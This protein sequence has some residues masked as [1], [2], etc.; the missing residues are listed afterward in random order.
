MSDAKLGIVFHDVPRLTGAEAQ[1]YNTLSVGQTEYWRT[2]TTNAVSP[3]FAII[4]S[5]T[6]QNEMQEIVATNTK[7]KITIGGVFN[8]TV[9]DVKVK[10]D[11]ATGVTCDDYKDMTVKDPKGSY[12]P[13]QVGYGTPSRSDVTLQRIPGK[14]VWKIQRSVVDG[15]C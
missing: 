11:T 3:A 1:V 8:T 14:D 10:G 7:G 15:S 12:T 13:D 4:G 2:M 9:S 5:G 6:V